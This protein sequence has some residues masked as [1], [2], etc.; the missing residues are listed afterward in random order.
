MPRCAAQARNPA[1]GLVGTLREPD[2]RGF[3]VH[4]VLGRG[5]FGRRLE[6]SCWS[7]RDRLEVRHEFGLLRHNHKVFIDKGK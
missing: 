6:P 3:A 4:L 5:D 2:K 7:L 1:M